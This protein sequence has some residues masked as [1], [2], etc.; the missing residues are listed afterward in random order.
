MENL[1]FLQ[2]VLGTVYVSKSNKEELTFNY[3]FL[4]KE[5]KSLLNKIHN[6][7]MTDEESSLILEDWQIE[8]LQ[9]QSDRI[10]FDSNK[11]VIEYPQYYTQEELTIINILK[12]TTY[13]PDTLT[14]EEIQILIKYFKNRKLVEDILSSSGNGLKLNKRSLSIVIKLF[15][16]KT[17]TT[18]KNI[19]NYESL[20][21]K[22]SLT[23]KEINKLE[24][25]IA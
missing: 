20:C 3:S 13:N 5:K 11:N 18:G 22:L 16:D 12:K 7:L 4:L 1:T 2:E 14:P 23:K 17:P 21:T 15:E 25:K 8:L 19:K 6:L 24:K 10:I 9:L